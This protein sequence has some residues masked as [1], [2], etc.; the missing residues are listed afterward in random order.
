[1][2]PALAFLV[3]IAASLAWLWS[4]RLL[5]DRLWWWAWIVPVAAT[6]ALVAVVL[7]DK[8][9][10]K[11]IG[12]LLMP[13]GLCWIALGALLTTALAGARWRSA[14][15]LAGVFALYT[16]AGNGWIGSALVRSLEAGIAQP[17]LDALERFDAVYVLGGGT[18]LAPSGA[19]QLSDAGDRVVVAARLYALGKAEVLVASA[20]A[21]PE[22][23]GD[24][25]D[26]AAETATLWQG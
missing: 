16:A 8:A 26:F 1:M 18:S 25:R 11:C 19:P 23:D 21:T 10:Q 17:Q 13:A 14:A 15:A 22:R 7:Q 24:G 20:R 3:V 6:A 2:L 4:G 12:L 9:V 5:K